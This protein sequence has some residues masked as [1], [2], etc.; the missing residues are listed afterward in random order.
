MKTCSKCKIEKPFEDFNKRSAA[1]DGLH[2]HCRECAKAYYASYYSTPEAKDKR[3]ERL[4]KPEVRSRN[5]RIQRSDKYREKRKA[6][7][8]I[9][10]PSKLNNYTKKYR[11]TEKGKITVSRYRIKRLGR[12]ASGGWSSTEVFDSANWQCFYCGIDVVQ[13]A[14]APRSDTK[15]TKHTQI[16][17]YH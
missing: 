17:S 16:I 7:I 1:K 8:A 13:P 11:A 2:P 5:N 3:A 14:R 4:N 12:T 15:L 6:W 10:E 9:Q